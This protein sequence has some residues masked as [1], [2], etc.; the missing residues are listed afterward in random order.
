MNSPKNA[1]VFIL[2]MNF[3][4]YDVLAF[5]VTENKNKNMLC[6]VPLGESAANQPQLNRTKYEPRCTAPPTQTYPVQ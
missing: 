3:N 2:A 5:E 4:V 6:S 1:K